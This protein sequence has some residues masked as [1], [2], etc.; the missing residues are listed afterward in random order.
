MKARVDK[1][2]C[3]GCGLCTSTCPTVFAMDDDGL[4]V[5]KPEAIDKAAEADADA[6]AADCPAA[7]IEI[8]PE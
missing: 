6:A 8:R 3:I 7:A 2:K 1:S 5:A 4:A